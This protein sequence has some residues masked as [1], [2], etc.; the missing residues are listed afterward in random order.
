MI[1]L[2][3]ILLCQ[4]WA[5]KHLCG[6]SIISPFIIQQLNSFMTATCHYFCLKC[7]LSRTC[8]NSQWLNSGPLNVHTYCLLNFISSL[9]MFSSNLLS[10]YE[11]L[12]SECC[13]ISLNFLTLIRIDSIFLFYFET[14]NKIHK[15]LN[16]FPQTL[17][18][19]W[20]LLFVISSQPFV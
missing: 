6:H 13:I 9:K 10:S 4:F 3:I 18:T 1:N 16:I 8:F 5:M 11:N 14:L 19:V 17:N 20:F 15:H 12:F 7:F 2:L